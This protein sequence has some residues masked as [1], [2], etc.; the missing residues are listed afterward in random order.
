MRHVVVLVAIASIAAVLTGHARA[1]TLLVANKSDHTLSFVSAESGETLATLE[2]GKNPHE[3]AVSPDGRLAVVSNYGDRSTAGHTLT[4]VDVENRRVLR[5]VDLGDN[6]RP[7]GLAFLSGNRVAVTTEGSAKLLMVDPKAGVAVGEVATMQSISH[8]VAVSK[9]NNR[10]FVA[11]IG[12]GTVTVID[13]AKAEKIRDIETGAGAEGIALSPDGKEVWVGNREAD[14]LTVIDSESLEIL[15]TIEAKGFPI[16]VAFTPDG[17]RVLVS[18][19][20]SGEVAAFDVAARKEVRRAKLDLSAVEG[21]ENRLFGDTF[22]K[23]PVPVGIVMAP[24]GKKAYVAATQADVVIAIDPVTLEVKDLL[25]AGH[26]PDGMA[27]AK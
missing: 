11:N 14:T 25:K 27:Y 24:D 2:T 3:V 13:L 26:E 9:D 5:T 8:M 19:A 22:G 4:I 16:R 18:C 17:N 7:H 10:A 21:S 6:T 12:S 1:G 20:Q 23:S 15:A